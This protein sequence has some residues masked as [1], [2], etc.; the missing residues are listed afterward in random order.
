MKTAEARAALAQAKQRPNQTAALRF[1]LATAAAEADAARS[2]GD[3]I[4]QLQAVVDEATGAGLVR[5][6]FEAR[7]LMARIE[8]R[9][10]QPAIG[11]RHLS[12][13][14]K[15]AAAKG[16]ALLAGKSAGGARRAPHAATVPPSRSGGFPQQ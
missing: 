14:K 15:E 8:I 6:A 9:S 13:M 4:T 10:G 3:A 11:C 1:L 16:F 7:L 12:S 2:P 5:A